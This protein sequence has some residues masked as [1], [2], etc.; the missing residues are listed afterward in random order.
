MDTNNDDDDD[1]DDD[2]GKNM[3]RK[4]QAKQKWKTGDV[5]VCVG[6]QQTDRKKLQMN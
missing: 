1:V 6:K 3:K 4:I 2:E 5:C